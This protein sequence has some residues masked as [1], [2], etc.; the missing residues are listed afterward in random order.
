MSLGLHTCA[1]S[2]NT[3][4]ALHSTHSRM[5]TSPL[6]SCIELPRAGPSRYL[7]PVMTPVGNPPPSADQKDV[8]CVCP[9]GTLLAQ[10]DLLPTRVLS[11]FSAKPLLCCGVPSL[12]HEAIPLYSKG[13]ALLFVEH[14]DILLDP[15]LPHL[16][17]TINL[18]PGL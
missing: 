4:V 2:F 15:F 16:K 11:I 6:Y 10:L 8:G 3:I 1:N 17:V 12:V 7:S 5:S 14:H 13:F 9:E 18:N